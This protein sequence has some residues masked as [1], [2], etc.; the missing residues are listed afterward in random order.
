[1]I[2]FQK[3][4]ATSNSY[5]FRFFPHLYQA[6]LEIEKQA[7][8]PEKLT[9]LRNEAFNKFLTKNNQNTIPNR[10][11]LTTRNQIEY[12]PPIEFD[13]KSKRLNPSLLNKEYYFKNFLP[14]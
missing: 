2:T 14:K 7:L 8:S 12:I 11:D 10:G 9:T 1:V 6:L 3:C 4:F 5:L 13:E